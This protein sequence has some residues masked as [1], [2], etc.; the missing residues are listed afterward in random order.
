ML[1]A[2]AISLRHLPRLGIYPPPPSGL[3][4]GRQAVQGGVHPRE[5]PGVP[6]GAAAGNAAPAGHPVHHRDPGVGGHLPGVFPP[7]DAMLSIL[8]ALPFG[9]VVTPI[10]GSFFLV[11]TPTLTL[12]FVPRRQL[13]YNDSDSLCDDVGG[14]FF[15]KGSLFPPRLRSNPVNR[16][17]PTNRG[18]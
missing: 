5:C 8:H 10:N 7:S 6:N 4:A 3:C 15:W 17:S 9:C 11:E 1:C 12:S 18:H 14:F 2:D 13:W 16:A